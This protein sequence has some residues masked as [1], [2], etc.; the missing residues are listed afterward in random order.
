MMIYRLPPLQNCCVSVLPLLQLV[1]LKT[2]VDFLICSCNLIDGGVLTFGLDLE[3]AVLGK[4]GECC[5]DF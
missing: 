5:I 2:P 3:G 1:F 4:F